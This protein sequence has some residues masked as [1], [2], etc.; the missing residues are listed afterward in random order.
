MTL[1]HNLRLR[2]IID[3]GRPI[4][5]LDELT[6]PCHANVFRCDLTDIVLCE[7]GN[8][9]VIARIPKPIGDG[10][11]CTRVLIVVVRRRRVDDEIVLEADRR[12]SRGERNRRIREIILDR[13][14]SADAIVLDRR[15][16]VIDL[17]RA[18]RVEDR[19]NHAGR[20]RQRL[21]ASLCI[22]DGVVLISA[23]HTV[24]LS[25]RITCRKIGERGIQPRIADCL[26]RH[27]A[28]GITADRRVCISCRIEVLS[29][30]QRERSCVESKCI[31][32][33]NTAED[34]IGRRQPRH[35]CRAVIV[36]DLA[37]DIDRERLLVDI[38]RKCRRRGSNRVVGGC[39]SR[40]REG[41]RVGD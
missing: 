39:R 8:V 4:I 27:T 29:A 30:D 31:P 5:G 24:V 12:R 25:G 35:I 19:M 20:N 14:S 36:L 6:E 13:S 21:D 15:S 2:R 28:V 33:G 23:V 17:L 37:C 16:A 34:D 3:I 7:V 11:S 41:Q 32:R 26:I 40:P 18:I 1:R 10:L 9:K 38:C 22:G